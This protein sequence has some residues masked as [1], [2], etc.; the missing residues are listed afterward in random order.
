[1]KNATVDVEFK[2]DDFESTTLHG[3]ELQAFSYEEVCSLLV[4]NCEISGFL[5]Q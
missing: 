2:Y 1:M 4:L 5:D 3:R